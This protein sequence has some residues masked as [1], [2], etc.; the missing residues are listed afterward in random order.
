[1]V[2]WYKQQGSLERLQ[3]QAKCKGG[4]WGDRSCGSHVVARATN[5]KYGRE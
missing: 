3:V 5:G 1:M 2:V 4:R